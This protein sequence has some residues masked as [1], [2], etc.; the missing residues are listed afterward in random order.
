[1]K[2][3]N[4]LFF[5]SPKISRFQIFS[6]FFFSLSF[7]FLFYLMQTT[8]SLQVLNEQR[9]PIPFCSSFDGAPASSLCSQQCMPPSFTPQSV[10]R[11]PYSSPSSPYPPRLAHHGWP[12]SSQVRP[13]L[14][15][16][17]SS[18]QCHFSSWDDQNGC[19]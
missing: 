17:E 1:M 13:W 6:F 14:P 5:F 2:S 9:G 8:V 19:V 16:M 7:F 3:I 11:P 18:N 12:W 15:L 10:A 4:C